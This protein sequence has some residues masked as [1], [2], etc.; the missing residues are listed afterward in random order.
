MDQGPRAKIIDRALKSSSVGIYFE[1]NF[2]VWA[3][4]PAW[5]FLWAQL[6]RTVELMNKDDC[7]LF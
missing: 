3:S 7:R 1:D 4:M 5:I 6:K 2:S